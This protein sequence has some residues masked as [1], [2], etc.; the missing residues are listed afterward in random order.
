MSRL[1]LIKK[2]GEDAIGWASYALY[3]DPTFSYQEQLETAE[4]REKPEH[5]PPS[6]ID[7]DVRTREEVIDFSQKESPKKT[8]VWVAMA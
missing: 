4:I 8:R 3:G 6:G 7:Q 1:S 2:H 5:R